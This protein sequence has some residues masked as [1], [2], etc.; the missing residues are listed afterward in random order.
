MCPECGC[1]ETIELG[2]VDDAP[3]Q[4]AGGTLARPSPQH[5]QIQLRGG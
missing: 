4:K 2:T 3:D 5:E 1:E